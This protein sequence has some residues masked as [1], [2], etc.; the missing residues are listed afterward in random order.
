MDHRESIE[1]VAAAL[2]PVHSGLPG[3][4]IQ[5]HFS[6]FILAFSIPRPKGRSAERIEKVKMRIEKCKISRSGLTV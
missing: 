2:N 6:I 1:R 3:R 5:L 4:C